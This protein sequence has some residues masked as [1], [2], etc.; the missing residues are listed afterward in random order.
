LKGRCLN[1]IS[2]SCYNDNFDV[3]PSLNRRH[4]VDNPGRACVHDD[5]CAGRYYKE[6]ARIA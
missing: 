1:V 3:R 2:S 4:D 5:D 6:E